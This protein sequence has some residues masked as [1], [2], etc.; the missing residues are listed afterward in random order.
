MIAAVNATGKIASLSGSSGGAATAAGANEVVLRVEGMMCTKSCTPAVEA[1]LRSV[2][3]VQDVMVSL[4][5]KSARVRGTAS[6]EAMIAAVNA[7]GKIASLSGSSGGAATAAGA[8][9][10]VLR[11]EG[12]MC[13]KSCTPAVE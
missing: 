10:V 9:E 8:S 12:M 5:Q 11:V 2:A 3:G 7:T 13:T 4:E 6:V 1:A